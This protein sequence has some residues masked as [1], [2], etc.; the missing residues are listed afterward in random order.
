MVGGTAESKEVWRLKSP[1]TAGS[2]PSLGGAEAPGQGRLGKVLCVQCN[3]EGFLPC[4]LLV[5]FLCQHSA[6]PNFKNMGALMS[7]PLSESS[8][9]KISVP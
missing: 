1:L 4:K 8:V 2:L 3:T 6:G 5:A 7:K 9:L